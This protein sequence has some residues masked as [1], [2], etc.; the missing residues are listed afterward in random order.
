MSPPL[1]EHQDG[2]QQ[3]F[4]VVRARK[5]FA[6]TCADKGWIEKAILGE[7]PFIEQLFRPR[8]QWTA[9][10]HLDRHPEAPFWAVDQRSRYVPVKDSAQEPFVLAGARIFERR[11]QA[12]YVFYDAMVK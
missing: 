8:P 4:V 12:P 5:L 6:P 11:R 1:L 3:P 7:A 10:P 2:P 9:K